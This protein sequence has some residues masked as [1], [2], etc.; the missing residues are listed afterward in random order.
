MFAIQRECAKHNYVSAIQDQSNTLDDRGYIIML[1]FNNND[2]YID[3][4]HGNAIPKRNVK[5]TLIFRIFPFR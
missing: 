2:T 3:V 1:L 5:T 4:A